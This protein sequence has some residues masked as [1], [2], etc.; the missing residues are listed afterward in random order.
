MCSSPCCLAFRHFPLILELSSSFKVTV[1]L[2]LVICEIS[3]ALGIGLGAW[4]SRKYH[5]CYYFGAE[6][7]SI[8]MRS[9]QPW[10][11][12]FFFPL[13]G[14][15]GERHLRHT[16]ALSSECFPSWKTNSTLIEMKTTWKLHLLLALNKRKLVWKNFSDQSFSIITGV[17]VKS[18]ASGSFQNCVGGLICFPSTYITGKLRFWNCY[19]TAG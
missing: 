19:F 15:L 7:Y 8:T 18:S 11:L 4:K 14:C 3:L 1:Q 9:S 17:S 5:I 2:N 6:A 13:Y 10:D 16:T 12:F